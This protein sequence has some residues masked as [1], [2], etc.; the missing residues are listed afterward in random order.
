MPRKAEVDVDPITYCVLRIQ[1][2][3]RNTQYIMSITRI[4]EDPLGIAYQWQCLY[5]GRVHNG[6]S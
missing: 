4:P 6:V 2:T 5:S 3:L 1:K